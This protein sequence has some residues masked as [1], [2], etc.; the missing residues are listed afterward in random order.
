M[1]TKEIKEKIRNAIGAKEVALYYTVPSN[2]RLGAYES[3]G[4]IRIEVG[5]DLGNE[6]AED[7]R[8][9]TYISCPG[10]G[11]ID[12]SYFSDNF[13]TRQEDGTYQIHDTGE[14]VS[15]SR[16]IEMSCEKGDIIDDIESIALKLYEAFQE[17]QE[18][19]KTFNG[20][21]I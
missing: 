1:K 5:P 17:E 18:R 12:T 3:N 8:P 16:M 11:N 15:E 13:A 14:M 19:Q 2:W 7:E 6:I 10:I 4:K 20:E 21:T 9:T